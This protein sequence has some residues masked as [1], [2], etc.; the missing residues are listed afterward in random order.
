MLWL[1]NDMEKKTLITLRRW[2]TDGDDRMVHINTHTQLTHLFRDSLI[3]WTFPIYNN[4]ILCISLS[5]P[6]V[7]SRWLTLFSLS[8][9]SFIKQNSW[10]QSVTYLHLAK[11]SNALLQKVFC[12]A[13]F[14]Q[15][16][17]VCIFLLMLTPTPFFC[18]AHTFTMIIPQKPCIIKSSKKK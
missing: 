5:F 3:H 13:A 18:S 2:L 6:C 16:L 17:C 15:L 7:L 9:H 10:T 12:G 8:L 1:D 11:Q 14:M 4:N